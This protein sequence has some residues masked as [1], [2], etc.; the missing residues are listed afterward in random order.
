MAGWTNLGKRRM[1]EWTYDNLSPPANFEIALVT[2]AT[3]PTPDL[4]L[5]SNYTEITGGGYARLTLTKGTSFD[6]PTDN[7]G[8]DIGSLQLVDQVWTASG[9]SLPTTGGARY[10]LLTDG[11]AGGTAEVYHY[12]DLGSDQQVSDGQTLTLQDAEMRMTE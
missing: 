7:D 4:D 10:A 1:L 11:V 9:G 6:T 5:M 2:S 12:W 3:P 8:T